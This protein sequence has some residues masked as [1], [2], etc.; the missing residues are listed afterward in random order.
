MYPCINKN[1]RPFVGD[2]RSGYLFAGFQDYWFAPGAGHTYKYL[3]RGRGSVFKAH[4]MGHPHYNRSGFFGFNAPPPFRLNC[5][6]WHHKKSSLHW[7][8]DCFLCR[9]STPGA[10]SELTSPLCLW[11]CSLVYHLFKKNARPNNNQ[12][13]TYYERVIYKEYTYN[14]YRRKQYKMC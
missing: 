13:I 10:Y 11:L 14:T 7:L 1:A 5:R 12:L 6:D 9:F 3:G 2:S 4:S 8:F